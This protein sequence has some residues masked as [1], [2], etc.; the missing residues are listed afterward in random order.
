MNMPPLPITRAPKGGG[1]VR[2][3]VMFMAEEA[4][5]CSEMETVTEW[6]ITNSEAA[7]VLGT[8]VR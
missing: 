6:K 1:P 4:K 7:V 8:P 3:R 2:R 5:R